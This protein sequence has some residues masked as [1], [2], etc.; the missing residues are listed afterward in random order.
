MTFGHGHNKRMWA[1]SIT[2]L[3]AISCGDAEVIDSP[4]APANSETID[5][6]TPNDGGDTQSVDCVQDI[7]CVPLLTGQN[8]QR[9]LCTDGQ[10]VL[11]PAADDMPCADGDLC[12]VDKRCIGGQCQGGAARKCDDQNPCTADTCEPQEGCTYASIAGSCDD[13]NPCTLADH[14]NG[15]KCV[16]GNSVCPC[17]DDAT[18]EQWN[19]SDKCNGDIRCMGGV[20]KIDPSTIVE[21]LEA[22]KD[23]C[24]KIGCNPATGLCGVVNLA[25]GTFC[26]DDNLCTGS[27]SCSAGSCVGGPA[28]CACTAD[29]DCLPLDD[30]DLCNGYLRC[31]GGQCTPDPSTQVSCPSA[32]DPCSPGGC[33][34]A[35][36][37]CGTTALA[38]GTS[39]DDGNPC[40]LGD[41]CL[42]GL[43]TG[44]P[45]ICDDANI[46]TDDLCDVGGNCNF[47]PN[48]AGCDDGKQC[49]QV[50]VCINGLCEGTNDTCSCTSQAECDQMPA[51]PCVGTLICINNVC[52]NDPTT[53]IV[54]DAGANTDCSANQCVGGLCMMQPINNG[55]ACFSG[56]PCVEGAT[57]AGGQCVPI[58]ESTCACK[59]EM[60]LTCSTTKPWSNEAFGSTDNIDAWSCAAG[61]FSGREYAFSFSTEVA[62]SV[63]VTLKNE[64]AKT[65]L[66]LV[67]DQG[68]GCLGSACIKTHTSTLT[69]LAQPF[70][71]YFIVV[72]GKDG[73][74]GKFDIKMTCNTEIESDC[75]DLVDNDFDGLIDCADE[76]CEGTP[77]CFGEK[78]NDGIDDDGD[79]LIDCA[80]PDCASKEDCETAC[81]A[82]ANAYCGL[83]TF[84]KTDGYG[85]T[86]D[87]VNYPCGSFTYDGPEFVYEYN[88][89][90]NAMVTVEL[91]QAFDG[92]GIF[93]M[94]DQGG[95]CNANSC[96]SFGTT[97]TQFYGIAGITYY[98]AIDG[99]SGTKGPFKISV[100]CN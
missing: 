28:A 25:D 64:A 79:G 85:S 31:I 81:T 10:C 11:V 94:Q 61:D 84:W 21:C 82:S 70:K 29:G 49:T 15:G 57:C 41:L 58:G 48:S 60:P 98:I 88:A 24:S 97:A 43:C 14:C 17:P 89:T 20:C 90:I 65:Q 27:D 38:N 92:H 12:W 55:A 54:C 74:A 32:A 33:D 36:G 22:D 83:S 19:D 67:E 73:T 23:A 9:P 40:T 13:G 68:Q 44:T 95:G 51:D 69:F 72:D 35:T 45:V 56:I 5:P 18:C 62:K 63:T 4:D 34:P 71:S 37:K 77:F 8:C 59:G 7:D 53:A 87:V 42:K 2:L 3:F 76:D 30:G 96:I 47:Q 52:T 16:A 80:D 93:V 6:D 75:G 50:D 99:M 46:C 91:P 66:F 26:D 78:C 100:K 86:N 1:L 39:C